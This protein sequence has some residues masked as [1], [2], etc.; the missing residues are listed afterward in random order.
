V[1]DDARPAAR[2][3]AVLNGIVAAM[4]LF[5]VLRC[6]GVGAYRAGVAPGG[7]FL[8]DFGT[9][10]QAA[11]RL[12]EGKQLYLHEEGPRLLYQCVS[13]PFIPVLVRPLGKLPVDAAFRIWVACNVTL[14]T[15][16]ALLFCWGA[17]MRFPE[18]IALVLLVLFTAFRYWP[19]VIEL[20][21][22][23]SDVI[24]LLAIAGMFVCNRYKKWMLFALL[25]AL[26]TLTKTW[27]IGSLFFL[28][29]RRKWNAAAA[30]LAFIAAG[31]AI[32]FTVV[33]WPEFARFLETTRRYSSQPDLVSLSVAG[34]A[35]MYFTANHVLKPWADNRA[36]YLA[37]L[38][39]GYGFLMAGLA[40]LWWK[41]PLMNSAQWRLLLALAAL[42]IILGSPVCHQFYYVLAL[43]LIWALLTGPGAWPVKLAAFA[44]YLV[45]SIPTPGLNPVAEVLRHGIRSAE[46]AIDFLTGMA[47][48]ALGLFELNREFSTPVNP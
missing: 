47:L 41:A 9:Y 31:A 44:L 42:A 18:D 24:L 3:N 19:A 27:M 5:L 10:H 30:A 45:F 11:R 48:W 4:L 38:A 32:L 16:A 22:G 21:M 40:Y 43:P 15:L 23:N 29:A 2:K 36:L 33:G 25:V 13:S 37:T 26:A 1:N 14:L 7:L 46:V 6:L 34:M 17:E 12:N 28:L 8:G 39:A 35:R 20:A